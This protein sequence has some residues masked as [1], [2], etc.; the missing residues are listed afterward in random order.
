MVF[1]EEVAEWLH[2][3]FDYAGTFADIGAMFQYWWD[4]FAAFLYNFWMQIS[5]L[6]N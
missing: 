5:G 2:N 3:A 1:F 4:G 6:F